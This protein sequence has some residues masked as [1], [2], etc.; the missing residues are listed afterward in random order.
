[1]SVGDLYEMIPLWSLPVMLVIVL[2]GS[3]IA[4]WTIQWMERKNH[5][6]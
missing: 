1:M 4:R 3:L 5:E 2:I 6:N